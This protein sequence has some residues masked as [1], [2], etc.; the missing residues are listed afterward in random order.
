MLEQK[1][2]ASGYQSNG[3]RSS[4]CESVYNVHSTE[5]SAE[6]WPSRHAGTLRLHGASSQGLDMPESLACYY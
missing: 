4:F 2:E 1:Y 3:P 6:I 5:S